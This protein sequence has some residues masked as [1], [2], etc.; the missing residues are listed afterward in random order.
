MS[1]VDAS[2]ASDTWLVSLHFVRAVLWSYYRAISRILSAC[3]RNA[4]TRFYLN[5]CFISYAYVIML[6]C[7]HNI[8]NHCQ[9]NTNGSE[10]NRE[11]FSD[12]HIN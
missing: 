6:S 8:M 1:A 9:K 2:T 10:R 4:D 7:A 5:H 12:N 3:F 11:R